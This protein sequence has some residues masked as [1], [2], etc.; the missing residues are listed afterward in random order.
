KEA[1]LIFRNRALVAAG[2]AGALVA[3]ARAGDPALL[4]E[5]FQAGLNETRWESVRIADAK[6][7]RIESGAGKLT[8]ALNTLGTD[9]AT[10][11]LRGVR[12]KQSFDV[13]TSLKAE[14]A[15]DWNAQANGCYL[16]AG[17]AFVDAAF[18]GDPRQA[19]E[20]VMF[21]WVGVPPGKNVRPYL[22]RH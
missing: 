4:S 2:L 16:S 17:L 1:A 13:N 15:I 18:D 14:T 6:S 21:E 8:L 7:D 9:G 3:L 12:T 10:V 19:Q 22:T 20:Y 11:K 5:T